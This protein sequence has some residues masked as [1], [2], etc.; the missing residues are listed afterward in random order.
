MQ[1]KILIF[2][3]LL[4]I[5]LIIVKI[6]KKS[7]VYDKNTNLPAQL[8]IIPTSSEIKEKKSIFIPYWTKFGDSTEFNNYDRLIYFGVSVNLNGINENEAG[9]TNLENFIETAKVAQKEK[10]LTVRMTDTDINLAILKNEK[11]WSKIILDTRDIVQKYK[12]DGIVL[13]LEIGTL[14]LN[15]I[16]KQI[17][18]FVQAF[19]SSIRGQNIKFALILYGD[20]FYR[21]RPYD[22]NILK[23]NT[24]EVMIMAYDFHKSYGEPGP[25]FPLFGQEEYGYDYQ[26]MFED[27]KSFLTPDKISVIF[28]MY[29]YDWIVDE[30]KRPI[31]RATSMSLHDINT[32]FIVNCTKENCVVKRDD[33]SKETEIDFIDKSLNYHIIWFEDK[34]SVEAKIEF[35]KENGVGN[36]IYWAYGYF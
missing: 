7:S 35:L 4:I 29:G 9:Y 14:N 8:T 31:K 28:G 22:L 13:D 36:I 2:L 25:N 11:S 30:K 3:I 32:K 12:L 23:D 20:N 5:L 18:R 1:K 10:W 21:K 34:N 19:Y 6:N 27:Y 33:K 24:D 26:K 16:D 17:S 15:N